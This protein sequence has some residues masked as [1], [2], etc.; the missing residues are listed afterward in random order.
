MSEP[1]KVLYVDDEADIRTIVG[2]ALGMDVAMDVVVAESGEDAL[3]RI[4]SGTW[5]PDIALI[6]MMMPGMSGMDLLEALRAREDT[7]SV[8]ILF[9]TAS[10]R[11]TE[12][13]RYTGA[14]AIGVISKPFDPVTL[15][16]LVRDHYDAHMGRTGG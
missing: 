5:L 12:I 13:H 11:S 4:G 3:E 2:L 7:T 9:V 14:G 10:A 8:P 1:L 6:D 15:A 16:R